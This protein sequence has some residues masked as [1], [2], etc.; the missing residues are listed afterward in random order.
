MVSTSTLKRLLLSTL[1]LALQ[2]I[3][4]NGFR[5]IP[6]ASTLVLR[7]QVRSKDCVELLTHQ[8]ELITLILTNNSC[9]LAALYLKENPIA[10]DK[11]T[12]HLT[13]RWPNDSLLPKQVEVATLRGIEFSPDVF[14]ESF[15]LPIPHDRDVCGY[16]VI[17]L[18]K[19]KTLSA[20]DL[21][22]L[23]KFVSSL[24]KIEQLYSQFSLN[25]VNED[26]TGLA[27]RLDRPSVC[28]F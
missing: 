20:K 24:S 18:F 7:L 1:L 17:S 27:S 15:S 19:D 23:R 12:Y 25:N 22:L 28:Y 26:F 4:I 16:L 9:S 5:S 11:E 14:Q 21:I 3:Q 6:Y 13:A 10:K 2:R 8:L